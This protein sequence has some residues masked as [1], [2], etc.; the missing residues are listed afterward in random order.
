[1]FKETFKNH[2]GNW[3]GAVRT[4]IQW[5]CVNGSSVTWGSHDELRAPITVKRLEDAA[6]EAAYAAIEPFMDI[7]KGIR[8]M[9]NMQ[10]N[11]KK[12]IHDILSEMYKALQKVSEHF[13]IDEITMELPKDASRLAEEA[14]LLIIEKNG[15]DIM[16]Q[17]IWGSITQKLWMISHK[18]K[19]KIH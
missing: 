14:R 2:G 4:W 10:L 18:L 15:N 9:V 17:T 7:E 6:G 3:L 1:M 11:E 8:E 12:D 13:H 16:L 19:W 5:N